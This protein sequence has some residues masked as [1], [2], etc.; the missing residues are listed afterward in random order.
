MAPHPLDP[1]SVAELQAAAG[2]CR[3]RNDP[4]AAPLRFNV[5]TLQARPGQLA[6]MASLPRELQLTS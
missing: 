2:A 4:D 5:I 3:A 1:L 6:E